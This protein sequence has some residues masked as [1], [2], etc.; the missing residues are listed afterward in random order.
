[1]PQQNA[2]ATFLDLI[3][4]VQDLACLRNLDKSEAYVDIKSKENLLF[5]ISNNAS[6]IINLNYFI[7]VATMIK[8]FHY[9]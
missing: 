9:S 8:C 5:H 1:V 7:L 4:N 3:A 6:I 2:D